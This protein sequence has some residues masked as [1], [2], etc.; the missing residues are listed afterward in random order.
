MLSSKDFWEN[1]YKT[2]KTEE[3][4]WTEEYPAVSLSFIDCLDLPK[5]AAIVDIGGGESK[6]PETLLKAGFENITV[7]DISENS[8]ERAKS[9]L[10]EKAEKINWIIEDILDFDCSVRFDYWHDRA[11]FHFLTEPEQISSYIKQAERLIN[12]NG[13]IT[14]GTFSKSGPEKC[15]GLP[16]IQ[17]DEYSL[18][19]S[20]SNSF[21]KL[22]C[23][24]HDH[25]TPFH[26]RQN[27]IYC[28]M[29]KI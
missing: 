3:L 1:I 2:K 20:F 18:I 14:I 26:T 17:Y 21:K 6:L 24:L 23:E 9:R 28:S 4:S 13:F 15:S 12:P 7:L 5:S 22:K 29:Q 25:E 10:G 11:T 19:K 16:V 8:I 27:F